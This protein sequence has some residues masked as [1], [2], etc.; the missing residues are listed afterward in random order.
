MELEIVIHLNIRNELP[1]SYCVGRLGMVLATDRHGLC[2]DDLPVGSSKHSKVVRLEDNYQGYYIFP[3][4][5]NTPEPL[6]RLIF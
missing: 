3:Y 1:S 5:R 6:P 4:Q 2:A